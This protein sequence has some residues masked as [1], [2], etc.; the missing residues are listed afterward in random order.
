VIEADTLPDWI[1]SGDIRVRLIVRATREQEAAPLRLTLLC[2]TT[3]EV[4]AADELASSQKVHAAARQR[5]PAITSR[6]VGVREVREVY[7]P[8]SQVTPYY[9]RYIRTQNPKLSPSDADRIAVAIVGY[10]IRYHIPDARLIVA[11]IMVESGFD[12]TSTSRSGAMGLGQLMPDTAKWMGVRDSYDILS[13]IEGCVKLVATHLGQYY[14]QTGDVDKSYML[15]LAA[16]N[17]GEGAVSRH[18]GVPPYRETIAY[19]KH[20]VTEYRLLRGY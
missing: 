17:A 9:A 1:T 10:S 11:I 2:S 12:P 19:I 3:E 6:G 20:V 16:Y 13:N 7:L 8:A 14:R 5:N 15:M 4:A 18:G